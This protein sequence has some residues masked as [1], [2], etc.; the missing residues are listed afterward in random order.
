MSRAITIRRSLLQNLVTVILLLGGGLFLTTL[1]GT[2]EAVETLSARVINQSADEVELALQRF[3]D[4]VEQSLVV[5]RSWGRDGILDLESTE[6]MN[7]LFQPVLEQTPQIA[8][9]LIADTAGAQYQILRDGT[10]F[11]NRLFRPG[12]WGDRAQRID[13]SV[14][15]PEPRTS[16]MEKEYDPTERPWFRDALS[17]LE[18]AE[19]AVHWTSPY[20]FITES[21]PGITAAA[22]FT[23][24][25]A[26]E[27]VIGFDVR[28][29]EITSFTVRERVT[30]N[31]LVAVLDANGRL[32]GLPAFP[33]F[34]DPSSWRN[35]LLKT[36]EELEVP[37]IEDAN[38]A[39]GERGTP[40]GPPI[41]FRSG[42]ELWW[43]Q[44]RALPLSNDTNLLI[45]IL[46]P[47]TDVFGERRALR[48][49]ILGLTGLVLVVAVV[50]A[51]S[52]AHRF[53]EPM[54]A[55]AAESDRISKGDLEEGERIE[56]EL[57]EVR[58]LAMAHEHMRVGLASLMKMERDIQ[59]ARQIQ[60]STFP[61]ELPRIDGF[62]VAAW[63]D[64]ADETG[65]DTYDLIPFDA[66][67][68][69]TVE[70]ALL[71][72]ADATGHGIGPAL[73][74]TQSRAMLRMAVR[75]DEGLP[76]IVK[77]LNE[78][79]HSDLPGNR[80]LTAW[81]GVLDAEAGILTS[82]SAGQ[83]PL[84]YY[85]AAEGR[86]ESSSANTMPLGLMPDIPIGVP[87]PIPMARGDIFVVLS[88]GIFEAVGDDDEQFGEERVVE[89]LERHKSATASEILASIRASVEAF[90]A[91]R[92][93]DDDRTAW[94][95]KRE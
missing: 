17:K 84:L 40:G 42:G 77:N 48:T 57:K 41:S 54:E 49:W 80:F 34:A 69:G 10:A 27:F 20:I 64:P 83:A 2:R 21:E 26:A 32:L 50:R 14:D 15:E 3:F 11:W 91:D 94:I 74:A 13:W 22:A 61:R 63:N 45:A 1:F 85:H 62:D 59:V 88:D 4:P 67:S 86:I 36:P 7:R 93:A 29:E 35:A 8:S 65:G 33:R 81:F 24:D 23:S 44:S 30:R 72:L 9:V 25:D 82:F 28:L 76:G 79:L 55:L 89:L 68:D 66:D 46:V 47:D 6:A 95:V 56:S 92:P 43:A 51:M 38:R 37:L 39:F 73:V 87:P 90:V 70:R 75:L 31:G 18:E 16:W 78:Q 58:Q 5:A 53:S 19:A 12:A 52:A 71:L 60:Q